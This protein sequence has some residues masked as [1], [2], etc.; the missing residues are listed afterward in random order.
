MRW[1]HLLDHII[2][3]TL[4]RAART[5]FI[6]FCFAISIENGTAGICAAGTCTDTIETKLWQTI[7]FLWRT[8]ECFVENVFW[9]KLHVKSEASV[10]PL[11]SI[12]R[13]QS[14]FRKFDS[15]HSGCSLSCLYKENFVVNTLLYLL[16]LRSGANFLLVQPLICLFMLSDLLKHLLQ[17][18]HW[19]L[20][21]VL[22]IS[23]CLD[24]AAARSNSFS[25]I[26]HFSI[27]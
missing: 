19:N 11:S 13:L 23:L 9:Q 1:W 7:I 17:T 10:L 16:H 15:L 4:I 8:R 18:G 3:K 26:V 14:F 24:T 20:L 27:I 6:I 5:S 12:G 21:S 25:Q 2:Y 22:C